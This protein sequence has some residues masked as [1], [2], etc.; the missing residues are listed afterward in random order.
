[1]L[2]F[3]ITQHNEC[4]KLQNVYC[5]NLICSKPLKDGGVKGIGAILLS[6]YLFSINNNNNKNIP[7][8]GLLELANSYINVGGLCLYSKFGFEYDPNLHGEDCF[9]D[10]NN[11]PMIVNLTEKYQNR[12]VNRTLIEILNGKNIFDKPYIC[13]LRDIRQTAFGIAKNIDKFISENANEYIVDDYL[14][15]TNDTYNY[16][17]FYSRLQN[18]PAKITELIDSIINNVATDIQLKELLVGVI[19]SENTI[20]PSTTP[21]T[22]PLPPPSKKKLSTMPLPDAKRRKIA[23]TGG[24]YYSKNRRKNKKNRK[25]TRKYKNGKIILLKK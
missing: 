12:D 23:A 2:G 17:L 11:M 24:R 7:K 5:L 25:Y 3:A 4:I 1:M 21:S 13:S 20:T 14:T 15:A 18:D 16:Q 8:I 6:L 10:N 9:D 19:I 22:T